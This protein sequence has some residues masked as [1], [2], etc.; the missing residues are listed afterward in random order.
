MFPPHHFPQLIRKNTITYPKA[1]HLDADGGEAF[2][3]WEK[4][5]NA[6][7]VMILCIGGGGGGGGGTSGASNTNRGG[8]GGG[9][10]GLVWVGIFPAILLPSHLRVV[11]GAG[12]LPGAAGSGAGGNGGL[13]Y[14]SVSGLASGPQD[15]LV[16]ATGGNGAAGGNSNLGGNAGTSPGN[17]S[18]TGSDAWPSNTL[19]IWHANG[20]SASMSG[21]GGSSGSAGVNAGFGT[22]PFAGAGG[23]G[24]ANS[25]NTSFA[26]GAVPLSGP[27]PGIPGGATGGGGGMHGV[28]TWD[29]VFSAVTH[30]AA[31]LQFLAA[32]G[33]SG[34]GG[35]GTGAGGQ[36][37]DGWYGCGGG[38]G[39]A[40]TT[41][42]RGGAGGRGLIII[43]TA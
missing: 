10:N 4:P 28:S 23:G 24:S 43:A 11:C 30:R 9:G 18:V 36:G 37:G 20:P 27:H 42:G 38:G 26:G 17:P 29:A 19:G 13:S 39:G 8:G 34:G 16:R 21:G 33:G 3:I 40:G 31:I 2:D 32:C 7:C 41:G 22:F 35:N 12:G 15:Y 6:G 1:L 14:V 5:S 25:S